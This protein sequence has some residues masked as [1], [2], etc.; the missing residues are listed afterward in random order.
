[1]GLE[2]RRH[3]Q[4]WRGKPLSHN[5]CMPRCR[6]HDNAALSQDHFLAAGKHDG[7]YRFALF[8]FQLPMLTLE[9]TSA[10]LSK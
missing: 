10:C 7:R 8:C 3:E 9:V 2:D 5:G 4:L 1:M 6:F